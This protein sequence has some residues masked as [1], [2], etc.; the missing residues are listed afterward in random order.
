MKPAFA[1]HALRGEVHDM[2][3]AFAAQQRLQRIEVVVEVDTLEPNQ[4]RALLPFV[5]Q[6]SLMGFLGT[7]G[8]Q[9]I[10][11]TYRPRESRRTS[12]LNTSLSR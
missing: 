10:M 2:R 11:S 4:A 5:G 12:R 6:E 8:C 1:D 3:R 9:D 7:A